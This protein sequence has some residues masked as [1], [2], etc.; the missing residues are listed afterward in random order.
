MRGST[1]NLLDYHSKERLIQRGN[2]SELEVP[3]TEL[4]LV[5]AAPRVQVTFLRDCGRVAVSSTDSADLLV[6][7]E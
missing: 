2:I 1:C 7:K 6:R 4:T 5:I 3:V